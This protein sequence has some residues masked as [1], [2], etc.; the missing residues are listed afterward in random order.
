M[1][2]DQ[3]PSTT[4]DDV[5]TEAQHYLSNVGNVSEKTDPLKWWK[6]HQKLYPRI[7]ILARK[8]LCAVSTST[9]SER[10]FSDC[11]NTLTTKRNKLDDTGVQNQVMLKR[12]MPQLNV[13][14]S[15]LA[16]MLRKKQRV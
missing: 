16:D 15:E 1:E 7:A 14:A 11:G 2:E 13:S 6:E 3:S 10:V 4:M 8:W 5:K 12:N 9:P